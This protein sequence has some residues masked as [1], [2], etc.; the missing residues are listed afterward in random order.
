V[1]VK[2]AAWTVWE[3]FK[4]HGIEPAPERGKVT[5][6][7]FLGGQAEAIL[8]C[9]FLE[10]RKLTG[11]RLYVFAVIGNASRR[12]QI[13]G[14]TAHPTAAWVVQF[15]RNLIMDHAD[16]CDSPLICS[17]A[18]L[19]LGRRSA[20]VRADIGSARRRQTLHMGCWWYG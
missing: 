15:G 13:L 7:A 20:Q 14:A 18:V 3:I 12:V 4:A 9:G 17:R 5:W 16:A 11:A 10:A 8:A 2:V 1:G 6:A 19:D